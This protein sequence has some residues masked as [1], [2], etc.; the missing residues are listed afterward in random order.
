[1]HKKFTYPHLCSMLC[2]SVE[3]AHNM[4]IYKQIMMSQQKQDVLSLYS[5]NNLQNPINLQDSIS[6]ILGIQ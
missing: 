3:Q 1:M 5:L 6:E 2:L 4:I